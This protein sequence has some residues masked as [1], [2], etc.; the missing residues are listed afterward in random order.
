MDTIALNIFLLLTDQECHNIYSMSR[1]DAE[2]PGR[3]RL[4]REG[5]RFDHAYTPV[6]ICMSAQ[7]HC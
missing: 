4:Q 5:I 7:R 6:S 2:T 3:N 1:F